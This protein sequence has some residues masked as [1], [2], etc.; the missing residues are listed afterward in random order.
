MSRAERLPQAKR[1]TKTRFGARLSPEGAKAFAIVLLASAPVLAATS[2]CPT[3]IGDNTLSA[4]N[5]ESNGMSGGSTISTGG[6]IA[7]D[8]TFGNF[9]SSGDAITA[10]TSIDAV[11]VPTN[12]A[13]E[14]EGLTSL[15][16][17]GDGTDTGNLTFVTQFGTTQPAVN[18][19]VTQ[20][21]FELENVTI[22]AE[23]TSG[24]SSIGLTLGVCENPTNDGGVGN[25]GSLASFTACTSLGGTYESVSETFSNPTS[26]AEVSINLFVALTVPDTIKLL[27]VDDTITITSESESGSS[28]NGIYDYFEASEPSTF[29]LFGTA[30]AGVGLLRFL[31]RKA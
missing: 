17:T 21:V 20:V 4:I 24:T 9:G 11:M 18:P 30:L 5:A 25:N 29:L 19:G 8:E 16:V 31:R 27:T 2:S 7:T 13:Q 3:S 23:T 15:G 1:S 26:S 22:A 14:F 10:T 28:Y 6:C 12:V